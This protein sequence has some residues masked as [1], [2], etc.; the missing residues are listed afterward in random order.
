M[1]YRDVVRIALPSMVELILTQLASMVDLMMVGQLGPWALTAVGLATQP[2]FLVMMLFMSMNV[3]ATAMIA[4]H[5]GAGNPEKA[6]MVLRQALLLTFVSGVVSSVLGYIFAE[7]LIRFMGAPD[8]ATLEGGT[9]YF[10]WQCIGLLG[11]ALSSAA[12]AA[13]RGVGNSRTAMTYNLIA[14]VVNVVFN[15]LLIYGSFGFPRWEVMGASLATIIGQFVAFFLAMAA[16]LRGKNYIKLRLTDSFKPHRETLNSVVRI[17]LP[18][19]AEQA[20]MRVG[21]MAYAKIVASLGTVLYATHMACMNIQAMSFMIGQAFAVSATALVGQSLG[22][23]RPD[24]AHHYTSRTNRIGMA[25]SVLLALS[26]VFLGRQIVA[27]YVGEGPDSAVIIGMGALVLRMVALMLPLQSSQ[28]ILGGSLR[29]AGDT[30]AIAFITFITVLLIRPGIA[31][32]TVMAL[33]WGLVGAWVALILDQ[34]L[35][36]FLV[37]MRYRTGKW[38][39]VIK[40]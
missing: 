36:S 38:T 4:R 17:G 37:L 21:M 19:L 8:A 12:T 30:S 2:K 29:G 25:V 5:R 6:N 13:L 16:L 28:F 9:V 10:Q 22:K 11:L 23:H 39:T 7:D 24:M 18:A 3:G 14:N 32:L 33:R 35:R 26:F 34:A 15:Y 1:L 20:I 27:L 40:D 31:G